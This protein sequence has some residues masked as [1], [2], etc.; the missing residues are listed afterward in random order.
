MSLTQYFAA[1]TLDGFVADPDGTL[2][3]L[4]SRRRDEAG[5]MSY[6]GFIAGVGAMAMGATSYEWILAHEFA[7]KDPADW[8]WPY[9]VP[10]WVFTHRD[11]PAV[12]NADVRFTSGDVAAVHPAMVAAAGGRNVW[13]LGGGNL[14]SQFA[15]TG[16]L[17]EVI[18]KIAPVVIGAGAPLLPRPV[19]L[20]LE[21]VARNVDFVG[22]RFSVVRPDQG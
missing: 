11:L 5:P 7:G 18:V 12:P 20:R 8:I 9:D 10:C 14:A 22:A 6:G 3:W 1:M 15:D 19:E 13:I 4:T 21:D 16:I 2:D 17:D